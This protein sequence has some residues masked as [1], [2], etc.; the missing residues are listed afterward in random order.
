MDEKQARMSRQPDNDRS[1]SL[2]ARCGDFVERRVLGSR[3]SNDWSLDSDQH[4]GKRRKYSRRVYSAPGTSFL[5]KRGNAAT[6]RKRNRPRQD[7]NRARAAVFSLLRTSSIFLRERR[8][9]RDGSRMFSRNDTVRVDTATKGNP[10]ER[11]ERF[12]ERKLIDVTGES[13]LNT[14]KAP[15]LLIAFRRQRSVHKVNR[16]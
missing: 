9:S 1:R 14:C 10:G 16:L 7:S 2:R 13:Y 4:R 11:S 12:A 8:T 6:R 5:E 3:F 15:S